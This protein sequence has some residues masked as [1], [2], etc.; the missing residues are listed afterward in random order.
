M[1]NT[2]Y[3]LVSAKTFEVSYNEVDLEESE[4][5]VR[6]TYLSICK[7]DQR[8]YQGDRDPQILAEKLPMALIHEGIGKVVHDSSGK[9]EIGD[10]VVMVPNTPVEYDN[11]VAENYLKSSRFKSSGFDG[12]LQEYV[13]TTSDRVLKIDNDINPYLAAFTELISIC[14]HSVDR[15]DKFAHERRNTIGIWGDGNVGFITSLL[16]KELFPETE[17]VVLGRNHEKLSHF[18]FADKVMLINEVPNEFEVDHAFE[19]VG[20]MNSQ[21]AIEQII[22]YI[23]PQ[24]TISL[25]GV[26]EYPIS[27]NTRMILEKGISLF[28]SSRSG[29]KDFERVLDIFKKHESIIPYLENLIVETVR[30]RNIDDIKDAFEKDIVIDFGKVIMIWDK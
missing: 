24:G 3:R 18:T 29:K 5:I 22:K 1:I 15:M 27:I 10:T 25:L 28:G 13:T 8:Y 9:F 6:P 17:V 23:N 7:A 19:C 26:S 30:I 12:F 20:G 16:F 2:V 11:I 21:T 4:L 14:V